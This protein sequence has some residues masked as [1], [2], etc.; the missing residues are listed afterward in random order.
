MLC[1]KRNKQIIKKKNRIKPYIH[2]QNIKEITTEEFLKETITCNQCKKRFNLES[3]EIK[4]H[5]AGCNQFYH[6]GIAGKCNCN[7]CKTI[8]RDNK[9]HNLSW[10]VNC[11]PKIEINKEKKDGIGY[12]VCKI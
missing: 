9:V 4:I 11:A 12:C 3:N 1:F 6:C 5:C 8:L 10:C 2:H 7:E